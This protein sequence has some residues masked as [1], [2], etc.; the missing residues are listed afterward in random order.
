V[1][2]FVRILKLH[3]QHPAEQVQQAVEHALA[4]G[5]PHADGVALC[6]RQLTA[7]ESVLPSLDLSD[8]PELLAVATEAPDLTCYDQL[9]GGR[10]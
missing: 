10:A 8:H 2:E 1:R 3:H 6:L 4:H 7:P 5:C 9:L